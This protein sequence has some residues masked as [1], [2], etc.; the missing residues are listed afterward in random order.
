M[1]EAASSATKTKGYDMYK[2][3]GIIQTAKTIW[4]EEGALAL[5]GGMS[6]HLLRVVPN[7]A[8]MFF[9]YE[10]V[11]HFGKQEKV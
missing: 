2:Y 6:A 11:L 5:Y 8:I 3:R 4:T 1:R 7:A 10:A 9:C